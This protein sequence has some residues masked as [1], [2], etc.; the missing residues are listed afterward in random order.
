M[1]K[2]NLFYQK[3]IRLLSV[4]ICDKNLI[5]LFCLNTY[6]FCALIFDKENGE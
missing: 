6:L 1:K 4:S 5:Y 2:S 3:N